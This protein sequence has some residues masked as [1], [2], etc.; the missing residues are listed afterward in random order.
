[1]RNPAPGPLCAVLPVAVWTPAVF[2]RTRPRAH[3][4]GG[5]LGAL[6]CRRRQVS[7]PRP[8]VL[9]KAALVR[10]SAVERRFRDC[11]T[12]QDLLA[13]YIQPEVAHVPHRR[14]VM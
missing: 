10:D 12:G 8:V 11:G 2:D 14:D 4:S 5:E 7:K 13:R 1:M 9:R 6:S 3:L